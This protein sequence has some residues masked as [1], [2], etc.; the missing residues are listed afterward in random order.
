MSLES[1]IDRPK[2]LL[3]VICESLTIKI[4][5]KKIFGEVF[6]PMDFINDKQLKDLE[7]YWKN[8][9]NGINYIA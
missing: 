2:E 4:I 7:T 1:L 9:Y 8:K 3:E 6:T 5:E